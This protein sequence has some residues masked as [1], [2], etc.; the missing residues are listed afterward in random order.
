M[1]N[2]Y[3]AHLIIDNFG[4]LMAK[5][6]KLHLFDVD[7]PEFKFRESSAVN[8]GSTIVAPLQTPVG[9]LGLMIVNIDHIDKLKYIINIYNFQCYDLRFPELSTILRKQGANVLTYPS[10][11]AMS[12]G[13]A[14]WEV[15]LRSRAIETQCFVIASAQIGFH[16]EKRE[17]YGH[18]IVSYIVRFLK[19]YSFLFIWIIF[20]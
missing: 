6:Q 16:N 19:I 10:A 5:Y 1:D 2:I 18:G 12:T 4:Q 14:H 11:F 3:N 9:Q 7:T 20:V 17:S 15:L 8:G 13:K